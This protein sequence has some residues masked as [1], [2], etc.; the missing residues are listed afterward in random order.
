MLSG[1]TALRDGQHRDALEVAETLRRAV[2][3]LA[4]VGQTGLHYATDPFDRERYSQVAGVAE[5]LRALLTR[6]PPEGLAPLLDPDGGHVTPKVDVRSA[7]FDDQGRILLVR[8]RSD[9]HWAPPGG[10]CDPLEPPASNAVREI[11]EEAG[12]QAK[13]LRLAAV[14]DRDTRGHRPRMPVTVYKLFFVCEP[15]SVG[16]GTRDGKEILD[17][18]WFAMD[19][20]PP[21]SA[22]RIQREELEIC[23]AS[24]R[25]P[26]LPTVVD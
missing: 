6:V 14:L 21:L 4:A 25:D 16:E 20:L 7:V 22:T 2:V 23:Y 24:W 3:E 10:W 15:L 13:L 19:D 8:E 11:A 9:G 26:S 5:A 1:V 18:G 12:V 17:V